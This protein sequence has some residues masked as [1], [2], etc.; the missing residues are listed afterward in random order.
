[1][2]Y[3]VSYIFIIP[4]LIILLVA[5]YFFVSKFARKDYKGA[6]VS[7]LRFVVYGGL[8][9]FVLFLL[10]SAAYYAGGGH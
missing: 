7:L 1:M 3:G 2:I 4:P 5:L 8:I 9:L 6:S 10:W